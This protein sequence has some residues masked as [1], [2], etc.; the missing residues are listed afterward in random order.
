M[1]VR[2]SGAGG[3]GFSPG[4]AP[5]LR[6]QRA[7]HR[8]RREVGKEE[9]KKKGERERENRWEKAVV[10]RPSMRVGYKFGADQTCYRTVPPVLGPLPPPP[11]RDRGTHQQNGYRAGGADTTRSG[12]REALTPSS[13]RYMQPISSERAPPHCSPSPYSL[14]FPSFY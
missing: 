2:R 7:T 14:D 5:L 6:A 1:K 8:K 4:P 9:R 3:K 10:F 11:L 13:P 12:P